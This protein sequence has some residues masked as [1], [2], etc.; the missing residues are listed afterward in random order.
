MEELQTFFF[1]AGFL[2]S[3]FQDFKKYVSA[4]GCEISF[5]IQEG[6]C[7]LPGLI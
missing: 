6:S 7:Y 4:P 2:S 3:C 1:D 5:E